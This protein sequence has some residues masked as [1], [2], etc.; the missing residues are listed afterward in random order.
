MPE[1]NEQQEQDQ[2]GSAAAPDE[3][4]PDRKPTETVEYWKAMSR[5]N[6]QQAK[7]NAAAAKKLAEIEERDLTELQKAQRDAETAKREAETARREAMT[8]RVA[9]QMG[10]AHLADR[11]RG[12]TIEEF[13]ADAELLLQLLPA[14]PQPHAAQQQPKDPGQ[15][16]APSKPGG[17]QAGIDLYHKLHPKKG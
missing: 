6:E 14:Q 1:E 11:L 2:Q 16:K 3:Q 12:T 15:G 13:E 9:A 17:Y 8:L 4:K 7:A 10:I 5:K